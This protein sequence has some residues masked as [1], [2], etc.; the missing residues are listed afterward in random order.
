M[1]G[2]I[3]VVD[4]N[5]IELSTFIQRC[6]IAYQAAMDKQED[7]VILNICQKL[8]G[9]AAELINSRNPNTF[10]Q[11]QNI[12]NTHLDIKHL[13]SVLL[14]LDTAKAKRKWKLVRLCQTSWKF[15]CYIDCNFIRDLI[16]TRIL[17]TNNRDLLIQNRITVIIIFQGDRWVNWNPIFKDI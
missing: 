10:T 15:R 1:F 2:F 16:R 11:I 12:L 6:N 17:T 3:A 8:Q 14:D 7:F 4:G 13:S 5:P 9:C